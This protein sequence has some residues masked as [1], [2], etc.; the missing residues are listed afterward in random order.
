MLPR[1]SSVLVVSAALLTGVV[2]VAAPS[3][4]GPPGT[5]TQISSVGNSTLEE[6]SLLRTGDGVLHVAMAG[7]AGN[8]SSIDVAHISANGS[9]NGRHTAVSNWTSITADPELVGAPGGGL[10]LLF[11]GLRTTTT[12][13]P[14]SEGYVY[15]AS[16]DATGQAWALG[17]N[18]TPA[19]KSNQGYA[20]YGTGATSL[21]DGTLVTAFPLNGTINYQVGNGPL[22]SFAVTCCAY[23]M[24]LVNDGGTVYAAWYANGAAPT[25]R[26]T[27]VRQLYPAL[28]PVLQAPGSASSAGSL[29]SGQSVAMV[30]R[31]G[32][33]T[34]L[35]YLT[36]YP[37]AKAVLLWQ[38]GSGAP[39]AVPGS[40]DAG[41]LALSNG[42]GGRLWLAFDDEKND[43]KVVRTDPSATKF[44]AVQNVEPPKGSSVYAVAI[45]GGTGRG[46]V[47]FN[48]G[49]RIWHQQVFAG[50]TLKAG[51]K[52]WNGDKQVAVTFKVTDAGAAIQGAKVKAKGLK[53]TTNKKGRCTLHFPKLKKGKFDAL[54][55]KKEYAAG[56][57]RLRVT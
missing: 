39:R 47:V 45:D 30:A 38:L 37:N 14:Y 20:S 22:Q 10:R 34:Y 27:F 3:H 11:G 16:S 31:P 19:V 36:G 8:I 4:A 55:T 49:T 52:K 26:G 46:D 44:G 32:G 6:P 43:I 1:R 54:A 5:W 53:C 29:G 17:P 25:E 24:T 7:E 41:S 50:L 28:G 42:A 12:L 48:D 35:A 23:D 2:G 56:S 33:G 57:V 51:P 9:L 21:A 18:T 13:D 40:K 15:Y